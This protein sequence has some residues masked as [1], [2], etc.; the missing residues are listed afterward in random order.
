MPRGAA[1]ENHHAFDVAQLRVGQLHLVE[2]DAAL[3]G[4]DAAEDGLLHRQRL[5]ENLLQ[6]EVLEA[7]LLG[8]HRIPRHA[9]RR[10]RAR[11]AG[12]IAERDALPR[13]HRHLLIVQ[14]HD[15]ARVAEDRGDVRGDE[16]F[17][18]AN[19]DDDRRAVARRHQLLRVVGGHQHE[20]EE[21]AD[22]LQADARRLFE[23]ARA[24]AE[25][26]RHQVRDDLGVGF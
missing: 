21:P 10:F 20:R 17:V 9:L 13:D 26:V 18:L 6:H 11:I 24:V 22:A 19:A 1:R 23:R 4:G 7:G 14:E 3:L 2:E 15:V 25:R 16:V 12:E 8:H 5:L